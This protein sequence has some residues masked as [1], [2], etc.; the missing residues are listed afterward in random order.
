M[1]NSQLRFGYHDQKS[2]TTTGVLGFQKP[3]K[4]VKDTLASDSGRFSISG[5][6]K[7]SCTIMFD[8]SKSFCSRVRKS[9]YVIPYYVIA[10]FVFSKTTQLTPPPTQ[11][12]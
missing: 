4:E 5:D 6:V 3:H 9:D 11:K 7:K 8:W 10:N 2:N 12:G 1:K